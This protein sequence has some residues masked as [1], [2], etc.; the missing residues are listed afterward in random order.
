MHRA[1]SAASRSCKQADISWEFCPNKTAEWQ[2]QVVLADLLAHRLGLRFRA[3]AEV[4]FAV[5]GEV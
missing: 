2:C 4:L 5:S 3:P 1:K